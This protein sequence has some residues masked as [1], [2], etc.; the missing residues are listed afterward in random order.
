VGEG[1]RILAR[2]AAVSTQ[3]VDRGP[4][5]KNRPSEKFT[6]QWGSK[7]EKRRGGIKTAFT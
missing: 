4:I 1:R 2:A 7:G 3:G 5:T 6:G